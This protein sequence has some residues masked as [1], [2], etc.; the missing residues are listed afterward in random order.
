[1]ENILFFFANLPVYSYGAML[2]LGLL[3]GSYLAQREG[4]RKGIGSEFIY[5][6]IVQATL[7]FIVAGR[8]S[9]DSGSTVGG[10]S[11]TLGCCS[12]VPSWMRVLACWV[13]LF[14]RSTFC[15]CM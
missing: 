3:V 10:F 5:R 13:R 7:V 8:F 9:C 12:A 15:L 14:T 1:M 6:F 11:F 2:G 4:K